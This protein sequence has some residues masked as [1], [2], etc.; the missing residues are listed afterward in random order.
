MMAHY[1]GEHP[2]KS[3]P[4]EDEIVV[5]L[6]E[7]NVALKAIQ[8]HVALAV[9]ESAV[10][11]LGDKVAAESQA[12]FDQNQDSG[13]FGKKN[14]LPKYMMKANSPFR[15]N[16][17]LFVI[18]LAIYNALSI[19][20]SIAYSPLS[21]ASPEFQ[22][23]DATVDFIFL[24]DIVL[25]FR[26]TFLDPARGE[27]ITDPVEIAYQYVRKGP[28]YLDLVSSLPFSDILSFAHNSEAFAQILDILGLLKLLR[29]LRISKFIAN[30]NSDA[31]FKTFL[32][33]LMLVLYTLVFLHLLACLWYVI[34]SGSEIWKLNMDF[35]WSYSTK[36]QQFFPENVTRQYLLTLY[37]SFY[38]FGLGEVC[39]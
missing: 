24:L 14:P 17:D 13:A 8:R 6:D 12:D 31:S 18:V 4:N 34:T 29:I 25:T 27:E 22:A 32:K 21:L 11:A 19:P 35:I 23:T 39:P 2:G 9:P 37:T 28:F 7:S 36:F 16:W 3:T 38:M 30:L 15:T 26:T 20:L 33:M 5:D 1:E 10:I